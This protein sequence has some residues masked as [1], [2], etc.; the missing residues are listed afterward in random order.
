MNTLDKETVQAALLDHFGDGFEVEA[1]EEGGLV[2]F[3]DEEALEM[4]LVTGEEATLAAFELSVVV[5]LAT[6]EAADKEMLENEC[7]EALEELFEADFG[8]G[9]YLAEK[10]AW[11]TGWSEDKDPDE[12]EPDVTFYSLA[13][14]CPVADTDDLIAVLEDIAASDLWIVSD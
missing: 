8:D 7:E 3:N 13:V 11:A 1:L 12:D 9:Y 10:G 2:I 6:Y 14:T 4:E 5:P